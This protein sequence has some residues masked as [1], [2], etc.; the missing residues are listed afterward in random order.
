MYLF[1]YNFTDNFSGYA[2]Y[3]Q[4]FRA[5]AYYEVNANF[6]NLRYGYRTISN[7]DLKPETSN[8]YEVGFRGRY[9]KIDYTFSAFYNDYSN[10]IERG[11]HFNNLKEKYFD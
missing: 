11:K 4:G 7:P 5:P 8:S 1:S 3:S 9:P 10:F 6:T 2:Q